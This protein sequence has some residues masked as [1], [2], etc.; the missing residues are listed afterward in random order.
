M[1][2]GCQAQIGPNFREETPV[3][4]TAAALNSAPEGDHTDHIIPGLTFRVGKKRRTWVL[5]YL[6][7]GTRH[8]PTIGYYVPNAPEGTESLGLAEARNKA[9]EILSRVE[10][11]VPVTVT[12][13][14]VAHPKDAMTLRTLIDEYEKMRR[15]Q[16][17]RGM[18][19]LDEALRTVRRCLADF[20]DLPARNFSKADLKKARDKAAKGVR[21]SGTGQM[22]DRFMSYLSPIMNWAA[23]E[24]HIEINLVTVTH[25][26]G[27]G[28][29]KRKRVLTDDEIRAIWRACGQFNSPEQQ[30]YG[31]L[32]RFL[33]VTAQR[34]EEGATVKHGDFI[35]GYWK[36]DEDANKSG[37][38]HLLKLPKLALDQ[39]GEGAADELCFPGK[40]QGKGLGG[41]S[42]FKIQLDKI[43]GVKGWRHHDLRR[44]AS[45]RMQESGVPPHIVD[46]VL[47]HAIAGVG[48]HYM[49]AAMNT[50][51]AEAIEGWA[52]ELKKI[53][54][55]KIGGVRPNEHE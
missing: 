17:G 13:E 54:I 25:R 21:K 32:V 26:V 40:M 43:S 11:G 53:I 37:R 50:Q 41:Y 31:R 24:D 16:G 6:A 44:T 45:T 55:G 7:G 12:E 39:L 46:A 9:R 5:R 47:N 49:H 29:V 51:K 34:K 23:K 18:K 15:A 38:E 33:L 35:G 19:S 1:L 52:T 2:Q 27:P 20:L 42:R 36:Q 22:A 3:K 8:K 48:A 14:K 10:A 30:T 28:L 4:L